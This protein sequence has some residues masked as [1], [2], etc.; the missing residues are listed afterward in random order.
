[1]S[2]NTMLS[3]L[4]TLV[5]DPSEDKFTEAIKLEQLNDAQSRVINLLNKNSLLELTRVQGSCVGNP[6]TLSGLSP[7]YY[8]SGGAIIMVQSDITGVICTPISIKSM[9]MLEIDVM[10]P[11]DEAPY[12]YLWDKKITVLPSTLAAQWKIFYISKPTAL[13]AGGDCDLST[14]VQ[15]IIKTIAEGLCWCIVDKLDRA[16]IAFNSAYAA[17]DSINKGV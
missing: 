8:G 13:I 3:D 2:V 9:K 16:E 6:Y 1:M 7:N 5:E 15:E 10:A 17:I 12:Y 14:A 11:T 4:G